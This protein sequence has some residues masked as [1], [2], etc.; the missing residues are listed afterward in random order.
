MALRQPIGYPIRCLVIRPKTSKTNQFAVIKR[1]TWIDSQIPRSCYCFYEKKPI[2]AS[3]AAKAGF[4]IYDFSARNY[5]KPSAFD[6]DRGLVLS[7]A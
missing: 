6:I 2:L 7:S 5:K 1:S 3:I 4:V